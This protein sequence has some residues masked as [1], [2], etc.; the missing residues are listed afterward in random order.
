[1]KRPQ[2][3]LIT[4]LIPLFGIC[5]NSINQSNTEK[6]RLK[7][8]SL[9]KQIKVL[10]DSLVKI[11]QEILAIQNTA[12]AKVGNQE[13]KTPLWGEIGIPFA[14]M[15]L[16]PKD[17][18]LVIDTIQESTKVKILDIDGFLAT[19]IKTEFNNKIGYIYKS[20]IKQNKQF[21]KFRDSVKIIKEREDKLLKQEKANNLAN[22]EKEDLLRAQEKAKQ[23]YKEKE[24]RLNQEYGI[25][26]TSKILNREIWIG[27]SKKM[28]IES[29]GK[30]KNVNR[31]VTPNIVTEQW[32]YLTKFLYFEENILTS[33]QESH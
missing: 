7:K 14:L 2:L 18:A 20:D 5:Q 33:W 32:V 16:E 10:Q 11:N 19:F 13:V 23:D 24:K 30:P 9:T 31:T 27:M 28:A 15:Y 8:E 6:L 25:A 12:I 29:L 17:Y 3:V 26:I 21:D 1:M 4:M 22:R